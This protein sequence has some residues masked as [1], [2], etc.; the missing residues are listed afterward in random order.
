MLHRGT[1]ALLAAAWLLCGVSQARAVELRPDPYNWTRTLSANAAAAPTCYCGCCAAHNWTGTAPGSAAT[2]SASMDTSSLTAVSTGTA[3]LGSFNI[4]LNASPQLMANPAAMAAFERAAARWEAVISDPITVTINA[5][6]RS[7]GAGQE[8]TIGVADSVM[9]FDE[10]DDEILTSWKAEAALD[11]ENGLVAAIPGA[12]S[13]TSLVPNG[14]VNNRRLGATKA[15]LKAMNVPDDLDGIFGAVDG[16]IEFNSDFQFDYDNSDGINFLQMDFE[17]AAMHEI[18]H[19]LGF[20][21]AVDDIDFLMSNPPSGVSPPYAIS[22]NPLDLFR[23]ARDGVNDP[24]TLAE[25]TSMPRE[26]RPGESATLDFITDLD[27]LPAELRV[28]TGALNGDGRQA[29]HWKDNNLT[30]MYIG[31]LDPTL[32]SGQIF[33]ITT[34]DLRALDLIGWD[35]VVTVPEPGSLLLALLAA[36]GGL[37]LV[38][39]RSA[40]RSS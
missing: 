38:R 35:I 26:W 15:N 2:F 4:V 1:A 19:V 10:F 12:A 20:V 17:S 31:A 21:S 37:L 18:G 5:S 24:T 32:S 39:R 40:G 23:F 22:P 6:I 30:G 8:N 29:S 16:A 36:G 25:F 3:S 34:A 9:L 13:L 11:P 33:Q 14:F 27:D 7:F 28:S